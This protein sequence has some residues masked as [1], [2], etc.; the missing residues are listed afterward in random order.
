MLNGANGLAR[1][2]GFTASAEVEHCRVYER[3]AGETLACGTG[4]YS[5]GDV[6]VCTPC[7]NGYYC[8]GTTAN[9]GALTACPAGSYTPSGTTPMIIFS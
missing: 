6:S 1:E 8:T 4:A 2:F 9:S 3:G 5:N 7:N